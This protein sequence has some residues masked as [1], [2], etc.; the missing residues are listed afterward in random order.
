MNEKFFDLKKEKQDRMINAALK[1]FA[2]N[3]YRHASTDDI[4]VEAGISKGL[5][6]H[7]FGSKIGL[8]AFL[9]DYC[10]RFS[11]LELKTCIS[12]SETD[13]FKIMKG[14]E[15]GKYAY[16]KTYPYMQLFI[17]RSQSED[18]E[19]ALDITAAMRNELQELYDGFLNQVDASAFK[20][21]VEPAEI[22][23]IL[24]YTL[25]GIMNEQLQA[26]IFNVDAYYNDAIKYIDMLK[27]MSY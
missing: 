13:F 7:Y 2:K 24:N 12:D 6:F 19:E 14:M 20:N 11:N 3:G 8:Y 22:Y 16:L 18:A 4:V 1:I 10:V 25:R 15:T 27:N 26:N 9:Y 23:S 21:G 17:D 5:L